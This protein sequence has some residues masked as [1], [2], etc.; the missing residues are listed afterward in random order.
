MFIL[1]MDVLGH[2]LED[3][4]HEMEGLLLL[5]RGCV[6]DQ[7]FPDDTTF[8]LKGTPNNLNKFRVVLGMFCR[9]SGAKVNWGKSMTIW[10]NKG[11]REWEWGQKVELRW[12]PEGECVQYFGI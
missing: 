2:M 10:A 3:P 5:K 11:K 6:Q 9:T 7:T 12:I 4:K 1:A 8:Y